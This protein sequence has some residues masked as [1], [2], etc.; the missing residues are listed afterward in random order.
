MTVHDRIKNNLDDMFNWMQDTE[1]E[2]TPAAFGTALNKALEL[3]LSEDVTTPVAEEVLP[4]FTDP[5]YATPRI[6]A[7]QFKDS[8]QQMRLAAYMIALFADMAQSKLD[9]MRD[10][11]GKVI[12]AAIIL[13][14]PELGGHGDADTCEGCSG[15]DDS[16]PQ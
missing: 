1:G 11:A 9:A 16:V 5:I 4:L 8:S 12:M 2:I 6:A 7:I 3:G 13:E 15:C 10:Y 14:T